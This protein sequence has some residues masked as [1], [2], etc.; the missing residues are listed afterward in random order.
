MLKIVITPVGNIILGELES[1]DLTEV[2]LNNPRE[3]Q[4]VQSANGQTKFAIIKL[5]GAPSTITLRIQ[6]MMCM[7]NC[8]EP[9]IQ[10]S[11]AESC[12]LLTRPKPNEVID[13][14]KSRH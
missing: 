2:K 9:S 6:N 5:F 12:G 11:Y 1:E 13:I 3:I 10:G 7:Y 8:E 14:I 4:I